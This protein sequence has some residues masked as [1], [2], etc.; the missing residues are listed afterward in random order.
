MS[1]AVERLTALAVLGGASPAR[2]RQIAEAVAAGRPVPPPDTDEAP[3]W[4]G[5]PSVG[6]ANA[7]LRELA[8][9]KRK[10]RRRAA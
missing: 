1:D 6:A 7:R 5:G 2:A 4:P 10:G 9:I 8:G 3:A